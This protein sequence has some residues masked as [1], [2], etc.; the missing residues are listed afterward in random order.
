MGS[1]LTNV[2][3]LS[4]NIC[5]ALIALLKILCAYSNPVSTGFAKQTM[6][7]LRILCYNGNLITLTV[8]SLTTAELESFILFCSSIRTP[9]RY[10]VSAMTA[11][12]ISLPTGTPMLRVTAV[13]YQ[14]PFLWLYCYLFEKIGHNIIQILNH[15]KEILDLF[16]WICVFCFD[17]MGVMREATRP[18]PEC[19]PC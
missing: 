7:I 10:I 16:F 4:S 17:V 8:V 1:S 6:P 15:V 19:Y 2:L 12:K 11:Q 5:I 14:W 18:F 13:T 9:S 3:P